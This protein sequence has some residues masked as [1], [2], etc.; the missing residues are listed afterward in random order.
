[1]VPAPGSPRLLPMPVWL[2]ILGVAVCLIPGI[3]A[4]VVFVLSVEDMREFIGSIVYT[5]VIFGVVV[6][7]LTAVALAPPLCW[8]CGWRPG[9]LGCSLYLSMIGF[10]FLFGSGE[11]DR[12]LSALFIPHVPLAGLLGWEWRGTIRRRQ[13]APDSCTAPSMDE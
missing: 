9:A 11:F 10:N 6:L 3:A 12:Y 4:L 2:R 7:P 8:A 1:M 13:A 5:L